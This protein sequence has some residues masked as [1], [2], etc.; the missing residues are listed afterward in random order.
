MG[1]LALRAHQRRGR[2]FARQRLHA[3]GHWRAHG[4]VERAAA[5][6]VL[7]HLRLRPVRRH[8]L[9]VPL[10]SGGQ[11]RG[12]VREL[13]AQVCQ[14]R[15]LWVLLQILRD[16]AGAALHQLRVHHHRLERLLR[17]AG[18]D[19]LPAQ[20]AAQ[21]AAAQP[22][23][24]ATATVAAAAV[25]AASS[26]HNRVLDCPQFSDWIVTKECKWCI[27]EG[28]VGPGMPLRTPRFLR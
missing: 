20:P 1:Q 7:R 14:H 21:P 5:R 24:V 8:D 17:Q 11:Q 13:R 16:V 22:A 15:E 23:A 12:H 9:H 2:R 3:A 4:H 10:G 28:F 18:R 27:P 19:H 25:A 26:K 6:E